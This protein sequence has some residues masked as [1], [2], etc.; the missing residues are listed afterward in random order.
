[1]MLWLGESRGYLTDYV[2]QC[3]VRLTGR[4]VVLAEHAWLAGPI[5]TARGIGPRFFDELARREALDIR[6]GGPDGDRGLI[7]DFHAL[8][9]PDFEA[10]LPEWYRDPDSKRGSKMERNYSAP[11]GMAGMKG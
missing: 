9:S 5:A 8:A 1:M 4:R 6:R 7:S 3:W 11:A 10:Q 2:T